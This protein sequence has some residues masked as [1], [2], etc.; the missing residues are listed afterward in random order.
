[1][2]NTY[3]AQVAFTVVVEN[4]CV[5][6]GIDRGLRMD[7]CGQTCPVKDEAFPGVG[8]GTRIWDSASHHRLAM[9]S[10]G[11]GCEVAKNRADTGIDIVN[12]RSRN[13]RRARLADNGVA[14]NTKKL[15]PLPRGLRIGLLI[16]NRKQRQGI[17]VSRG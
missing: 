1:I 8:I 6:D 3:S 14:V 13:T 5:Q 2:T 9:Y 7:N 11:N 4:D 16:S 15:V 17:R 10:T 12:E